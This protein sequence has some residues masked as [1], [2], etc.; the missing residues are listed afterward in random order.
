M[1]Q[2]HRTSSKLYVFRLSKVDLLV[3]I[4]SKVRAHS[5]PASSCG[6]FLR[7]NLM[8][9][10]KD[11]LTKALGIVMIAAGVLG[12]IGWL[13][14][15]VLGYLLSGGTADGRSDVPL[16]FLVPIVVGFVGAILSLITGVM[17]VAKGASPGKAKIVFAAFTA[18]SYLPGIVILARMWWYF[19]AVPAFLFGFA[20]PV[21][22][23]VRIIVIGRK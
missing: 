21:I 11:G 9:N 5:P 20:P 3:R 18:L 17:A 12:I 1:I 16:E 14:L 4:K 19:A 15:A 23:L 6:R 2:V 7:K 8:N 22:Y 10:G 13:L